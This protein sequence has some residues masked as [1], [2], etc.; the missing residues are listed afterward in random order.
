MI[1]LQKLFL[2]KYS[3]MKC[4]QIVK[5]LFI[6]PFPFTSSLQPTVVSA[7]C[8][9]ELHGEGEDDGR[10]LLRGDGVEGLQVPGLRG[11]VRVMSCHIAS[12]CDMLRH[13]ASCRVML[14][15]VGSCHVML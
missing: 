5:K 2:F 4:L 15:Y 12:C 13:V 9:N 10:V 8:A 11:L 14:L 6:D 7:E 1:V 3:L